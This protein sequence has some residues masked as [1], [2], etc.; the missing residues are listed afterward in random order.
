MNYKTIITILLVF[1]FVGGVAA[2]DS[3]PLLPDEFRGSVTIN[4]NPAPA[5]T[6]L[7]AL[8]NGEV[9]GTLTTTETGSYGGLELEDRRLIVTGYDGE[10]GAT[11]TFTVG[12]HTAKETATFSPGETQRLNLSATYTPPSPGGSGGGGGG[13]GG[14][15][16]QEPVVSPDTVLGE[17][18][19]TTSSTGSL[20]GSVT[21]SSVDKKVSLYL[22]K[23]TGVYDSVGKP[24]STIRI[25]Q[26]ATLPAVPSGFTFEGYSCECKPE[27][28][29]FS[30]AI[31]ISFSIPDDEW[32]EGKDYK[33]RCYNAATGLWEN[34]PTTVNAATHT[35]SARVTHFSCFALFTGSAAVTTATKA[36]VSATTVP[37]TAAAA[38]PAASGSTEAG[39]L[40]WTTILVVCIVVGVVA[41]GAYYIKKK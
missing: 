13:S 24:L 2:E 21:V 4:G 17:A 18:S 22:P 39:T 36:P 26:A 29:T 3:L 28:A 37:T 20:L 35:V 8:I 5:G 30:P 38:I 31:T 6:V 27:G 23:G 41:G 33:I 32:V 40:P 14:P 12:G 1:A 19:L 25:Q 11:I 9:R 7:T 34:L 16:Y 10:V 15:I